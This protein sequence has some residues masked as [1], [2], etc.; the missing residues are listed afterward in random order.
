MHDGPLADLFRSTDASKEAGNTV[1]PTPPAP[2]ETIEATQMMDPPVE[3]VP[4]QPPV[5]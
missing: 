1:E 4:P 5:T 3:I 2:E